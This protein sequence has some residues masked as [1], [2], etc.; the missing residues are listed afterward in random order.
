M[1]LPRVLILLSITVAVTSRHLQKRDWVP[2]RDWARCADLERQA[3]G[4]LTVMREIMRGDGL[5]SLVTNG[6]LN[7]DCSSATLERN[8]QLSIEASDMCVSSTDTDITVFASA[9]SRIC[10][11]KE[12]FIQSETCLS[13]GAPVEARRNCHVD[14]TDYE[15]RCREEPVCIENNLR[16]G[17]EC[18]ARI[19]S[20]LRGLA[21]IEFEP[22][23]GDNCIYYVF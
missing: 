11:N 8:R 17:S 16:E 14:T 6:A 23:M 19:A 7:L 13:S 15:R 12:A 2:P 9:Y 21:A 5:N 22:L 18:S 20:I 1:T 10:T 4:N 3:L